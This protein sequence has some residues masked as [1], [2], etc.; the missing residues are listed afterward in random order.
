MHLA[1]DGPV[2]VGEDL[3]FKDSVVVDGRL[4][5]LLRKYE[6]TAKVSMTRA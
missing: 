6:S 1:W 3:L 5:G 4:E 2:L